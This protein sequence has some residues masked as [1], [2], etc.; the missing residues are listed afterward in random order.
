MLAV[1]FHGEQILPPLLGML[2]V[3]AGISGSLRLWLRRA[4]RD[5]KV[6]KSFYLTASIP[7]L[8]IFVLRSAFAIL[9]LPFAAMTLYYQLTY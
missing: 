9:I 3:V 6:R 8:T 4:Y 5:G 1:Y 2:V 7:L